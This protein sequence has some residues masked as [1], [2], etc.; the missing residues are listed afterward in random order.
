MESITFKCRTVTPL[1]SRSMILYGNRYLFELRPQSIKGVLRFWFRALAPTVID[2]NYYKE[3]KES[4]I[5][6]KKLEEAIFGST[7]KRSPFSINVLWNEK[8]TKSVEELISTNKYLFRNSLFGLYPFRRG[9]PYYSYL[10]PDSKLLVKFR[11]SSKAPKSLSEFIASLFGLVAYYGGL[12]AKTHDGYGSFSVKKIINVKAARTFADFPKQTAERL[13]DVINELHSSSKT[14][15]FN[16]NENIPL[17][18]A[19]LKPD[20]FPNLVHAKDKEI[21]KGRRNWREIIKETTSLR[22]RNGEPIT[23]WAGK[24]LDLRGRNSSKDIMDNFRDV[25]FRKGTLPNNL[26]IKTSIM[27]LPIN[28]QRIG[29]T[30]RETGSG[31]AKVNNLVDGDPGRKASPLNITIQKDEAGKYFAR[32][33]LMA[34]LISEKRR[35]GSPV[36]S[37]KT[38]NNK[39]FEVLGYENFDDLWNRYSTEGY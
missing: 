14:N 35:N 9:D 17:L 37:V 13:I 7:E 27:G 10:K 36:V 21:F 24:K 39:N 25:I 16:L 3:K 11:F 33:L 32:I 38:S 2:I 19:D 26:E 23:G 8:N 20:D 22:N 1:F 4:L 12:G 15:L 31:S 29:K 30:Q 6:L 34:S 18:F 5:G 28:Y